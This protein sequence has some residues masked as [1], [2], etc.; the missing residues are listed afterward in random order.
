MPLEYRVDKARLSALSMIYAVLSLILLTRLFILQ[1]TQYDLYQHKAAMNLKASLYEPAFRGQIYDREGRLL[2]SNNRHFD[3]YIEDGTEK[4]IAK[5]LKALQ[6]IWG[7]EMKEQVWKRASTQPL[8]E[9]LLVKKDLTLQELARLSPWLSEHPQLQIKERYLRSYPFGAACA[10]LIGY[11]QPERLFRH[12]KPDI[13]SERAIAGLEARCD[14]TLRGQPSK[15]LVSK[16][17]QNHRIHKERITPSES[18]QNLRLT[19]NVSWQQKAYE[20]LAANNLS[21]SIVVLD[22]ASGEILVAASAPSFDPEKIRYEPEL[23]HDDIQRPLFFRAFQGLYPP[24]SLIK[25]F[26][27]IAAL[28]EGQITPQ[29]QIDDPGY[30]QPAGSNQRFHDWKKK[31]HGKVNVQKAIAQSCDTFFY[32]LGDSLGIDVLHDWLRSFGFGQSFEHLPLTVTSGLLP[33]KRWKAERLKTP[34]YRGDSIQTAIGQGYLSATPLH[35]AYATALIA[36]KGQTPLP[37]ILQDKAPIWPDFIEPLQQI[38]C[39]DLIHKSM[40]QVIDSPLGTAHHKLASIKIDIAGKTGTAQVISHQTQHHSQK[41]YHDHSL[42]MAYGPRKHPK[43]ACVV[44]I[45]NHAGATV[46]AGELLTQIFRDL[47][48]TPKEIN[49]T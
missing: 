43:I 30:Y 15:I 48:E 5:L 9:P 37:Q 12:H 10:H 36:S 39:W 21:G 1:V 4:T 49:D 19:I 24:A 2:S 8:F 22:V 20:L 28:E 32:I 29:T 14:Q 13:R 41:K 46:M 18:G 11:T 42:F 44:V 35:L 17:A 33:S 7:A 40:E 26:V 23:Y 27:A 16:N 45:E 6:P 34:W 3:L 25:P 31:G 47:S 38:A